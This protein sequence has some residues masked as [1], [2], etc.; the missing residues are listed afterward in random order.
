MFLWHLAERKTVGVP[1][2]RNILRLSLIDISRYSLIP[3]CPLHFQ[4]FS[5]F[6]ELRTQL[7][8]SRLIGS[9]K[10]F[11][12]NQSTHL[13]PSFCQAQLWRLWRLQLCTVASAAR[14][15]KT[16]STSLRTISFHET[17]IQRSLRP[18]LYSWTDGWEWKC[19]FPAIMTKHH[20]LG[21]D[22]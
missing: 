15:K 13:V 11:I 7:N 10:M 3:L 18:P 21:N 19:I 16:K 17:Q 8:S 2:Q 22:M 5:C 9:K 12:T 1:N 6:F 4:C 14:E 20:S